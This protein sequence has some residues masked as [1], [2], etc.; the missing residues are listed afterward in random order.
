V[1]AHSNGCVPERGAGGLAERYWADKIFALPPE[2]ITPAL[3]W[4][5]VVTYTL[6][7]YFDFSGYSDMAIGLG[8]LFGF[9]FLENFRYPYVARSITD[10]WRRWHISLSTWFRDYLYI[11]LGGNRGGQAR[12]YA[13]LM[14]VFLLCGL[15]HGASL[16]FVAWGAYHGLFLVLER[17]GLGAWLERRGAWL[18]HV[19]TMS[20]VM[21]GWVFFRADTFYEASRFLAAMVGIQDGSQPIDLGTTIVAANVLNPVGLFADARTWIAIAVGIVGSMPVLPAAAAW[22]KSLWDSDRNS[23]RSSPRRRAGIC[24]ATTGYS[25]RTPN[26]ALPWRN[27]RG[28]Q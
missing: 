2:Q 27:E 24:I 18:R 14:I 7:I 6:Q 28:R 3:A 1:A 26:C 19:Y 21:V 20:V 8:H 11:P 16:T 9:K 15:W 10:F 4:L 23:K 25:P 12:T 22:T 13:N 17:V 5:G